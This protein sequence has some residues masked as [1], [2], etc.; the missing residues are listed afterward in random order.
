MHIHHLNPIAQVDETGRVLPLRKALESVRPVC[1]SCHAI[2]HSRT[3]L[4]SL[5]E[6]RK[7][8]EEVEKA[9]QAPISDT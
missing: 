6:A 2:V 3:P 9:R 4:L 1:P 5:E 8:W 7:V